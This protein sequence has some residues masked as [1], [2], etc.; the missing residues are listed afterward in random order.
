MAERWMAVRIVEEPD[1]CM[2][3]TDYHFWCRVVGTP[4]HPAEPRARLIVASPRLLAVC[5]DIYDQLTRAVERTGHYPIR[6][7]SI[8]GLRHAIVEAG[9]NLEGPGGA[10]PAAEPQAE[11][12]TTGDDQAA[13]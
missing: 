8:D 5:E 11:A 9:G 7:V 10:S 12:A 3:G 4:G 1:T 2:I 13:G 6:P